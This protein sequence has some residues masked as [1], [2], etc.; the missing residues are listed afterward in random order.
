MKR[1]SLYNIHIAAAAPAHAAQLCIA[2]GPMLLTL[3]QC[4][5]VDPLVLPALRCRARS[6]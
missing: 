1:T 2:T 3:S 5:A 6:P 4:K